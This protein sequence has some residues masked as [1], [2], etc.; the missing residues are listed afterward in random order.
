MTDRLT[1]CMITTFYPPDHFG[2]DA[3]YVY[4]LANALAERGH[5]VHVIHDR[6]AFRMLGGKSSN[7]AFPH[8]PGVRVHA[9][10]SSLGALSAL[11]TQQTGLPGPKRAKIEAVLAEAKPDVIH[12]HNI[13]LV[14]GPG[15][16]RLGDALKLYTLHEHWLVCPTHVLWKFDR[17]ACEERACL[18]CQLRAKRPPQWWRYGTLLE[19]C[20]REVDLFLAPSEFTLR[21][22]R[23]W[24]GLD[25]PMRHLPNFYH[26]LGGER[27]STRGIA[28]AS[29]TGRPYFLAIGRLEKIKGFQDVIPIFDRF[30]DADLLVAGSG[31]YEPT[32]RRLAGANPRVKF[33]GHVDQHDLPELYT[34]AIATIAPSICYETFGMTVVESF[35]YGTPVVARNIG[36]LPELIERSRGGTVFHDTEELEECL[37]RIYAEPGKRDELGA[38]ALEAFGQEW[39]EEAHLNRYLNII[40][41][42]TIRRG[43]HGTA[44]ALAQSAGQSA[45]RPPDPPLVR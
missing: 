1:F 38:R 9:L 42:L 45:G 11:F 20:V 15:V 28:A 2:G 36:A 26:S 29:G 16:L 13:S 39:T 3:I 8:H 7:A 41:E 25:I 12:Y 33:L 34:N 32:L 17:E 31:G 22:H 19:D 14:G 6:D 24:G 44:E 5:E 27:D 18:S 40:E 4:R 35:A 43:P 23:D 30:E 10:K 21:R 37:R